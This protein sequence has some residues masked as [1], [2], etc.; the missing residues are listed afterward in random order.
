MRWRARQRR[1]INPLR[2]EVGLLLEKLGSTSDEIADSLRD[3]GIQG[4]PIQDSCP[5]A[6]YLRQHMGG[7]TVWVSPIDIWVDYHQLG[8]PPPPHVIGF[9]NKFDDETRRAYRT[10]E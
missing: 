6:I 4:Y 5:I 1:A 10:L 2:T 7:V 9:I 3:L 8:A